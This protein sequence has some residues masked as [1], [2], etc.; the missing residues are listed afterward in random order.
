MGG[1]PDHTHGSMVFDG[2]YKSVVYHGH[3]IGE[4]YDHA[5][6]PFEFDNLWDNPGARDLRAA[7]LKSH[8]D[9]MMETISA[10]P[11]RSVNY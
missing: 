8:L 3:A 10:G 1:H 5:N 11:P 7:M 6:D 9:A 2:R 4:L